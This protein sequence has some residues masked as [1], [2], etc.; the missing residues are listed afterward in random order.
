MCCEDSIELGCKCICEKY[1]ETASNSGVV[2]V[3]LGNS[4]AQC[5]NFG[6]FTSGDEIEIDFQQFNV[7]AGVELCMSIKYYDETNTLISE[8][9][10]KL[11]LTLCNQLI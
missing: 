10:Y 9:N 7:P 4:V 8:Q 6:A 11:K 5:K 3:C 2:V 1:K